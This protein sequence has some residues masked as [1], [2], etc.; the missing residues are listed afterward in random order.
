MNRTHPLVLELIGNKS[1]NTVAAYLG[2]LDTFMRFMGA[3][4][5]HS[6]VEHL[7]TQDYGRANALICG[8]RDHLTSRQGLTPATANRRLAVLRSLIRVARKRGLVPWTIDVASLAPG[9]NSERPVS[10][11]EFRRVLARL[12]DS[13]T[14]LRDAAMLRIIRD[15]ALKT[16]DVAELTLSDLSGIG[17]SPAT[18]RALDAWLDARGPAEGPLFPSL[19]SANGGDRLSTR[20]VLAVVKR[21][22]RAVGLDLTARALARG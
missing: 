20:G 4:D 5:V 16:S 18:R 19:S 9:S 12:G 2:D 6:A 8:F 11:S 1:D 22:G 10:A 13:P 17:L 14:D 3:N 21:R 7:L 15:L